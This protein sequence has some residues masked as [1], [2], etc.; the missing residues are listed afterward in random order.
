M[1]FG[2][3]LFQY[4]CTNL[5]FQGTWRWQYPYVKCVNNQCTQIRSFLVTW[6]SLSI[7]ESSLSWAMK[8][9]VWMNG[10]RSICVAVLCRNWRLFHHIIALFKVPY[11][12]TSVPRSS[13]LR[14]LSSAFTGTFPLWSS[15]S[16][17]SSLSSV[18]STTSLPS[19]SRSFV[20]KSLQHVELCLSCFWAISNV[21]WLLVPVLAWE[22]F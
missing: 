17:T 19:L 9:Q 1:Y 5:T 12:W 22:L 14:G 15:L 10:W 7:V 20:S 4:C 18:P 6:C 21:Q 3:G 16:F 2:T 13:L 11:R 8:G